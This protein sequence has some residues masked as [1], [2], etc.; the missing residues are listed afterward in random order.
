MHPTQ[1]GGTFLLLDL[2]DLGICSR[3]P[4]ARGS[5][6]RMFFGAGGSTLYF[7]LAFR[8][9]P[10]PLLIVSDS[11]DALPLQFGCMPI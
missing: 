9:R 3:A 10:H 6:R 11:I 5:G 4:P 8:P 2:E 7:E 1:G